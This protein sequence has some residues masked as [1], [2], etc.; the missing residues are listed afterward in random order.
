M[1]ILDAATLATAL[2]E[3]P[4]WELRPPAIVRE[5]V[6]ADFAAAIAFVNR[7]AAVAEEMDHHPDLAISWNR[8]TVS[9][10]SHRLGGVT[11]ACVA[12]ADAA[13]AAFAG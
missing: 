8:V 12:L 7:V 4:G 1:S 13:D 11:L 5:Y 10:H 3:R 9:I 2:A 6:L